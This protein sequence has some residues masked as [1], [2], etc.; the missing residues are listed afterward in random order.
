MDKPDVDKYEAVMAKMDLPQFWAA[1]ITAVVEAGVME[2]WQD[3]ADYIQLLETMAEDL[4]VHP[5]II[6]TLQDELAN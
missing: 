4:K 3:P 1:P 5:K 6:H 2:D